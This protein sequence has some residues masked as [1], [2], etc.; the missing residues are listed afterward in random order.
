M[1]TGQLQKARQEAGALA[2]LQ[3]ADRPAF[4]QLVAADQHQHHQRIKRIYHIV[5]LVIFKMIPS[6]IA[7]SRRICKHKRS[8]PLHT[9]G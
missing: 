9:G 2:Q 6:I 3:M 7:Q 4:Q 1:H 8:P 5:A